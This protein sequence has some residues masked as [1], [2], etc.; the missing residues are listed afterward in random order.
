MKRLALLAL[1]SSAAHA[2]TYNVDIAFNGVGPPGAP[3]LLN[4]FTG[5][6]TYANGAITSIAI[7]DPP[8]SDPGAPATQFTV[9]EVNPWAGPSPYTSLSFFDLEGAPSLAV[10]G[11]NV[12][13]FDIQVYGLGTSTPTIGD[14]GF[15][16]SGPSEISC[17]PDYDVY[18]CSVKTIGAAAVDAKAPE[19]SPQAETSVLL[20]GILLLLKGPI[21]LAAARVR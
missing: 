8:W 21:R 19:L 6:F 11:S 12:W 18:S 20:L 16:H 4:T 15:Y 1:L 5:S 17:G 2:Q 3:A 14:A 10:A 13:T 9:A 7:P